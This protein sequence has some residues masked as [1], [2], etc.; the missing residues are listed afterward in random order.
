MKAKVLAESF[1]AAPRVDK[2]ILLHPFQL[3]QPIRLRFTT[4]NSENMNIRKLPLTAWATVL[5]I[6][7]LNTPL[8]H[9][10]PPVA[11]R[12]AAS[13]PAVSKQATPTPFIFNR[14]PYPGGELFKGPAVPIQW[15]VT[16][17]KPPAPSAPRLKTTDQSL[18]KIQVYMDKTKMLELWEFAHGLKQEF[19][20]FRNIRLAS[21]PDSPFASFSD[22]AQSN[23]DT[24]LLWSSSHVSNWS[25]LE[26]IKWI[27][28][29]N[30]VSRYQGQESAYL[31]FAEE[32]DLEDPASAAPTPAANA[33]PSQG[34]AP[35]A[36]AQT[37][38]TAQAAAQQFPPGLIP[39]VPLKP[40]IRAALIDETTRLPKR[41]QFGLETLI[42]TYETKPENLAIPKKISSLIPPE[43]ISPE[44][45]KAP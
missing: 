27:K 2:I 13:G 43:L 10:A 20:T 36:S 45:P 32:Q 9:A 12:P 38:R 42:Y 15:T 39:G 4:L 23:P 16:F 18:V 5:A 17:Q 24:S 14:T 7:L 44:K 26:E 33:K 25:G 41:V 30:F 28:P 11:P 35:A 22:P 8:V 6:V 3:M 34:A 29:E 21:T 37:A 40:T 19:W 1:L 31:I